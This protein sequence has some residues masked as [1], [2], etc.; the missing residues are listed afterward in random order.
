MRKGE[1]VRWEGEIVR[2]EG[3]VVRWEGK[4]VWW[5]GGQ[6]SAVEKAREV[7]VAIE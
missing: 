3:K 4:I 6:G 7:I 2:W 1:V 5:E